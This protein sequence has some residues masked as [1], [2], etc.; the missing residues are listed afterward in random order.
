[1]KAVAC[2]LLSCAVSAAAQDYT[3]QSTLERLFDLEGKPPY[4]APGTLVF[5][6]LESKYDSGHG[7]GY[8][9]ELKIADRLRHSA[10]QTREHF[11][12]RVTPSLPDGAKSIVAQYHAVGLD[13][14][15]KVY[16]QDTSERKGL[17]GKANNGV[18]DI[19]ARITGAAGAETAT[20]L[21]TV[22]SGESFDLDIALNA[23]QAQV[24]VTTAAD[25][26]RQTEPTQVKQD[27]RA[28]Y[29]KFGDYLQAL[30]PATQAHTIEAAKW[31]QYYQQQHITAEHI[32]FSH[33]VFERREQ[34]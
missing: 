24:T 28:I 20:A 10:A 33:T 16:V 23:G 1:M 26:T 5:S 18:F 8:R 22:R 4:R 15:L 3:P 13:T 31:E 29:F 12:A 6:A 27:S 34:P 30:D 17:D 14:I 7:H 2:A 11:S 32:T 21:G 25:G 9:N 19:I